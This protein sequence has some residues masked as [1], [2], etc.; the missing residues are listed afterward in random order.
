MAIPDWDDA[1]HAWVEFQGIYQGNGIDPGD[2]HHAQGALTRVADATQE[3]IMEAIWQVW[4]LCPTH[5]HGLHA[6]LKN[7]TAIWQCTG[8]GT[9]TVA[10]V[11]DLP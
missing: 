6:A 11:G 3:V 2:A 10:P 4:P 1:G 9:H 7:E 5:N 8:S